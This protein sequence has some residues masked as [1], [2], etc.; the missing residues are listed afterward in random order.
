MAIGFGLVGCGGAA[1]DVARALDLVPDARIVAAFDRRAEHAEDL[2][3]AR[4]ATVHADLGSLLADDAVDVVYVGLPHDLLAP[5]ATE[6]IH[7]G[8]HVLVEK[9]MALTVEH[10]RA[11]ERLATERDVR[12]GVMF[13]TREVAA[14]RS[15]RDLLRSGA[16]G[17]VR[18]IRIQT[19]IDKP[20]R[21]WQSGA[22]GRVAD[23]WRA[24][25]E[26]AGGGVVLM[27]TIHQLDLVRWLTGRKVVRVSGQVAAAGDGVDVEDRAA[28]ALTLD[29]GTLVSLTATASSP[30]ARDQE[31]IEIDGSHGRLDLPDPYST[32][33]AQLYLRHIWEGLASGRWHPIDPEPVDPYVPFL[34]AVVAAVASG[35]PMPATPDDAAAALATVL[36]V[37][38]AATT[39]RTV[40]I[41]MP[42]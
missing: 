32:N 25:R 26:R 15:A 14:I 29:D 22:T 6:A 35:D 28:A 38:E 4:G 3:R 1:V 13:E 37:Y 18:A 21:Y 36:A 33:G 9:P 24:H 19:V 12:A 27:N 16:I 2:A 8:R 7:A 23:D 31:R 34:E 10:V 40:D 20:A 42:R 30:G 41:D 11:L 39:G 5:T 17:S